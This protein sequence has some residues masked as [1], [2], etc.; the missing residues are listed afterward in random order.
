MNVEWGQ[1]A[2]G[3]YGGSI[4]AG[5]AAVIA[6]DRHVKTF[7]ACPCAKSIHPVSLHREELVGIVELDQ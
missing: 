5:M 3:N 7:A 2:I 6:A 4:G 1:L